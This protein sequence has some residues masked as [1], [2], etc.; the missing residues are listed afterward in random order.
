MQAARLQ[1]AKKA[2]AQGWR[3]TLSGGR[4]NLNNEQGPPQAE[5][6]R[7]SVEKSEAI[8]NEKMEEEPSKLDVQETAQRDRYQRMAFNHWH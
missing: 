2:A 3:A 8:N 5:E 6:K 7:G 4:D 1:Q